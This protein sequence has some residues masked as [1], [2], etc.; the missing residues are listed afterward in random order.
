MLPSTEPEAPIQLRWLT[1]DIEKA[2]KSITYPLA[3]TTSPFGHGSIR[4]RAEAQGQVSS[5][6]QLALFRADAPLARTEAD[7]G[8]H[9]K[10]LG[11]GVE[12]PEPKKPTLGS[13][14]SEQSVIRDRE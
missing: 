11:G 10:S 6:S 3:A 13:V 8:E 4:E 2:S 14:A 5:V 9:L 7:L 12:A 1:Y